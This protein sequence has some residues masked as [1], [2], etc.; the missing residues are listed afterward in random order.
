MKNTLILSLLII[1]GIFG[2]NQYK[3]QTVAA[4]GAHD[5]EIQL[6]AD[7]IRSICE[8]AGASQEVEV[9]ID[10]SFVANTTTSTFFGLLATTQL[11]VNRLR[12]KRVWKIKAGTDG[13]RIR[14]NSIYLTL[15][16]LLSTTELQLEHEVLLQQ[17]VNWDPLAGGKM[18][19]L[20]RTKAEQRALDLGLLEFAKNSISATLTAMLPDNVNIYWE[21]D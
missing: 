13:I 18:V 10:T 6:N 15:P 4:I 2:Y 8:L 9:I 3:P 1:A 21:T 16:K 19:V 12:E 7:S 20:S 11:K 5:T 17:G 14:D